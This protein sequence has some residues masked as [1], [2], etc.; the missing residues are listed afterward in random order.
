MEHLPPEGVR[1][2]LAQPDR[3]CTKGRRDLV[4]LSTLFDSGERVQELIDLSIGDFIPGAN[5]VLVLIGK[6][7]KM[8]RIPLMKNTAGKDR[9]Q[10]SDHVIPTESGKHHHHHGGKKRYT[11][12]KPGEKAD[13]ATDHQR[14]PLVIQ[15]EQS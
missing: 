6:G 4:M 2:L 10:N 7:N 9:K 5:A 3:S 11:A 1:L 15:S 12:G 14:Y 8:R 13:H